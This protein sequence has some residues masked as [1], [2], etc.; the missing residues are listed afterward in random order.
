[1]AQFYTFKW[2]TKK[3]HMGN[4]KTQTHL[5]FLMSTFLFLV[6]THILTKPDV[7]VETISW[8]ATELY[9]YFSL[10]FFLVNFPFGRLTINYSLKALLACG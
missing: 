2:E 9:K 4:I 6:L 10:S 1:M 7:L 3:H 5:P 8:A